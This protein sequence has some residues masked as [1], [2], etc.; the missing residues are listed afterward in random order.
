MFLDRIFSRE[1]S[2]DATRIDREVRDLS[3]RMRRVEALLGVCD[4][5]AEVRDV[6]PPLRPGRRR[7]A[8][9]LDGALSSYEN[10]WARDRERSG[11]TD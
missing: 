7:Y 10:A 4:G 11:R 6:P 3:A 2:D 1:G 9:S 8:G 5:V